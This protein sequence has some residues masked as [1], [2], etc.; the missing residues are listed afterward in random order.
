MMGQLARNK[1]S[2]VMK[3]IPFLSNDTYLSVLFTWQLMRFYCKSLGRN[4][5][6][7]FA[8]LDAI[9]RGKD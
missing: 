8:I 6:P 3:L 7:Y 5:S 4:R 9:N 2:A 1:K